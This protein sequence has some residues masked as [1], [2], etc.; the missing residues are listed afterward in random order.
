MKRTAFTPRLGEAD[1]TQWC[2]ALFTVLKLILPCIY[3]LCSVYL[4]I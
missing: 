4:E 2:Y 1:Y 3:F